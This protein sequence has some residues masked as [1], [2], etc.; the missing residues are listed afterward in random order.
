[1]LVGPV[2]AVEWG[3]SSAMTVARP[4]HRKRDPDSTSWR[5][6][7]RAQLPLPLEPHGHF[8]P[9]SADTIQLPQRRLHVGPATA[10]NRS[11]YSR[12]RWLVRDRETT[13][14]GSVR[15]SFLSV[16]RSTLAGKSVLITCFLL[17]LVSRHSIFLLICLSRSEL[18]TNKI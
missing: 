1:M 10:T 7:W 15:L 8:F 5:R 14:V 18:R 3:L 16:R 2:A 13:V 9:S 11:S 17:S 12:V 6:R 4:R